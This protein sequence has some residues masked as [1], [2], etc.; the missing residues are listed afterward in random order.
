MPKL[1]VNSALGQKDIQLPNRPILSIP[2]ETG[3]ENVINEKGE[4]DRE[5][6][7]QLRQAAKQVSTGNRSTID[8]LLGLRRRNTEV[9]I[10][11]VTF[12][13]RSLK[14]GEILEANTLAR[15]NTKDGL[16]FFNHN[17]RLAILSFAIEKIDGIDTKLALQTEDINDI[18]TV[19]ANMQGEVT[20][21]IFEAYTKMFPSAEEVKEAGEELKK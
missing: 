15:Q 12:S 10:D 16:S 6:L 18:F 4:V 1:S 5:K 19:L 7:N 2:D 21:E 20:P 8:I 13:L 11:G 9:K 17:L 3:I 14:D